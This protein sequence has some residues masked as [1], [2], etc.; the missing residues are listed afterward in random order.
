MISI[1]YLMLYYVKREIEIHF[2]CTTFRE[3]AILVV[4]QMY[5]IFKVLLLIAAYYLYAVQI[6]SI[7]G[8]LYFH[9]L[10]NA[11]A[12]VQVTELCMDVACFGIIKHKYNQTEDHSG[13]NHIL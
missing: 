6:T 7:C 9:V 1:V 5:Y 10:V 12:V 2:Y 13:T 11:Y 4:A 8:G 3:Y